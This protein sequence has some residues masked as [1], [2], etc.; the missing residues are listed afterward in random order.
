MAQLKSTL[1]QF[2]SNG[3]GVVPVGANGSTFTRPEWALAGTW[4]VVPDLGPQQTNPG[5]GFASMFVA[6]GN[7]VGNT[8]TMANQSGDTLLLY[9]ETT[10]DSGGCAVSVDGGAPG[11]FAN[12]TS[13]SPTMTLTTYNPGPGNHTIVVQPSGAGKCYFYAAQWENA[14][15]SGVILNNIAH[16]YATTNAYCLTPSAQ[17]AV[18]P[19]I[20][21]APSLAIIELGV[22]EIIEGTINQATYSSQMQACVTYLRGINPN[23][24]ILFLD[25]YNINP[26]SIGTGITYAQVRTTEQSL[27]TSNNAAYMSIGDSWGTYAQANALGLMNGDGLHP[28]NLGGIN[29]GALVA[30][31]ITMGIN[32]LPLNTIKPF[33]VQQPYPADVSEYSL[34]NNNPQSPS[35]SKLSSGLN[36]FV[37]TTG[38]YATGFDLGINTVNGDYGPRLYN[39]DGN[40]SSSSDVIFQH[41]N[42]AAGIP[43]CQGAGCGW[44]QD[45]YVESNDSSLHIVGKLY[46]A[47]L[48]LPNCSSSASPAV[49]GANT[50]GSVVIATS[51]TS[52]VVNTTA[53]TAN[54]QILVVPDESLGTK[55]GVTCNTTA[56]VALASYGVTA[57]TSGTSFTIS[58]TGTVATNPACYSFTIVN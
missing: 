48:S 20:S 10:T 58:T 45:G 19:L 47:G 31:Y 27:A 18:V 37:N 26:A 6:S 49:C 28:S 41:Y 13:G 33:I 56:T 7:G 9:A 50:S 30:S 57:R 25:D 32:N 43:K 52:V 35:T 12:T 1:K 53:V 40:T 21:P 54:S 29:Y 22:N 44:I 16:G 14:N 15:T 5:A 55:L 3:T 23:M 34:L 17:M 39:N 36:L 51:A 2:G 24:S 4:A 11:I 38:R 42:H 46:G 8:L